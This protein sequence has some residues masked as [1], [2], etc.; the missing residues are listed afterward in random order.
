MGIFQQRISIAAT[1][2]GP[3]REMEAVVDTGS[4]YMW[5]R[6]SLLSEMGVR[7]IATRQFMLADGT[8]INRDVAEIVLRVDGQQVHTICVYGDEGTLSLLGAVALEQLALAV[9]P[10]NKRLVPMAQIPALSTPC[11]PPTGEKTGV[12]GP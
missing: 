8:L 5:L 11:S 7:P 6:R 12:R 3:F 2:E 4:L 1:P 10:V 9:D